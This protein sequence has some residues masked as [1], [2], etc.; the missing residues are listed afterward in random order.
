MRIRFLLAL[1]CFSLASGYSA[2]AQ[3]VTINLQ[4]VKLEKVFDAITKQTGLSVAYSRP[5]VNPDQNVSIIATNEELS[6]VLKRLFAGTNV[7]FEIG[8]EKIYLKDG[9]TSSNGSQQVKTKNVS[10]VIVD[11]NGEPVIGASV[12]VKGTNNG[13][14]TD[15]DGRFTVNDVSENST[16]DI[17][18]I[19]YKTLTLKASDKNLARLVLH[20]DTE[21]LDEVVV[22]GYTPMRKSDFT[23]SLA[24]V[25]S[26]ELSLSAATAGQALVGK[27]A[28][29]QVMQTTGAPGKGVEIKVR[30]TN[31]LSASTSP[32]YVIDGYPASEDVYINPEDI[33]TIDILKDAASAAIY[34]SRGASGVVLI[35]TKRGKTG[36]AQITYDFQYSVQQVAKKIDLL[37]ATQFRDL[38]IDARNN[39]YRDKAEAAGLSWSP[40]DD[41]AIRASKGFALSE[42]GIPDLF[43][44]FTTGK[45]VT[46]Q[47]N[48][49]WQDEIYSNAPMSRHNV[50]VAGGTENLKYRFSF[51]Y[52]NQD[53]IISPSNHKRMNVRANVDA[54]VTK[55]LR[56]GINFSFEDI[57]ERQVQADGRYINDGIVQSAL[58]MFPQFP[59]YNED[60]SYSVG[61]QIAMKSDG[62]QMVEN[63]V[64]LANEID[65]RYKLYRMNFNT[66]ITY[67]ILKNLQFKANLGTQYNTNRYNYYRPSTIGQDGDMPN[68]ES[69]KSRVKAIDKMNND[70]DYLGEFT[71]NYKGEWNKH[72]LDV[73]GGYTMQKKT[74]DKVVVNAQG[75]S[76]DRIHEITAH[77]PN[78][79]DI[80]LDS[81]TRKAAWTMMSYLGRIN[82]SY[83]NKYIITG[84]VRTDGSSRFG[85]ENR[86]GW[87]PSISIGWTTSN[88]K[89]YKDLFGDSSSLRLRASW[90]LSGNNNI[91]NY[92]HTATM[93]SGGYP[94]GGGVESA[95]WQGS[96]RDAA[97]GWEKTS[98][99]NA[100]FDLGLFNGRVNIIGNYYHSLS[101][102]LLYDQPI[103]A[104]SGSTSVKTN[105]NK[106][107]VLNQGVDFQVD[108][109]I[110]TG[111]FKWNLNANISVNRNKVLELGGI[112][113]LYIVSERNVVTHV[114]RSGLPIGSFYGYIQEGILSTDEYNKVMIDKG[115]MV[116]G[117]FPEGYKLQGPAVPNYNNVHPGDVKWKD[118]DGN[119]RITE[120]DRDILGNAYPDFTYGISTNMSYKN[121][122]LSATF[123][124]SEGAK[125]INFQKYYLYNMEGSG[126]QLASAADRW[127]SDE[128]PG[129]G[130]VFRA[131]R[132]STP[133]ISQRLSSYMVDD[134]SYFRC[135]NITLGYNFPSKW[136]NKMKVSSLRLYA[137]VDNLFTITDYEGYNPEVSSKGSNLLPGFDWGVYPLARTY[138]VGLKLSF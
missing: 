25:K 63:P 130:T 82:Y 131:T 114:T 70:I 62:F 76:D 97:V 95:Y 10:G 20:E 50:S 93:S 85:K 71:L 65:A 124:G 48:T 77:G 31:S 39:A 37:D 108:G 102:D 9:K 12:L 61:N 136:M 51:G 36:K 105:L 53:G 109:R 137:S 66:N 28:G 45:P 86:W 94:F 17:S 46:P 80:S 120:D 90:G 2:Y 96:F 83:N 26:N 126:N 56:V 106:A 128:Q 35:T 91:G 59:V 116:N 125:V 6:D 21:V 64:A 79:S 49:D 87:F 69:I 67:D 98:Q 123:T 60:G 42:V 30:G 47:Y 40:L 29:V 43:F 133:N 88:E 135:S 99:Y 27:V 121:F 38:V 44:D 11:T 74:Y 81:D 34:G 138:S 55:K 32:L 72:R 92:E 110:L 134:A 54:N 1:L 78:A 7:A 103:S 41:N 8:E 118:V 24:S 16:L 112:N 14:I 75:F 13:T 107:R 19:G 89:F 57:H 101:Y 119:G 113:D 132:T 18:Y 3:K 115:N 100:G 5:T 15:L 84:T 104:I 22:V 68:S 122:D 127:I 73:L 23:G 111:A 117:E 4:N 129:N 33:E 52:L 58:L